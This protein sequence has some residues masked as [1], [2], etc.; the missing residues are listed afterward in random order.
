MTLNPKT[1][2]NDDIPSERNKNVVP[3]YLQGLQELRKSQQLSDVIICCGGVKF[4]AHKVV[5]AANCPYLKAMFTNGMKE[6]TSNEIELK[7]V[8]PTTFGL[9]MDFMYSRDVSI[10]QSNVLD[11]IGASSLLQIEDLRQLSSKFL[12]RQIDC[13][14]VIMIRLFA[15][16]MFL[17]ELKE[18]ATTFLVDNFGKIILCDEFLTIGPDQLID[19]LKFDFL[20]VRSEYVAFYGA[21]RWIQNDLRSRK[22]HAITVLENIRL[23]HF[24]N[25]NYLT[26]IVDKL[27]QEIESPEDCEK[28]LENISKRCS[29][30]RLLGSVTE[31]T[32]SYPSSIRW[33]PQETIYAVGGRNRDSCLSSLESYDPTNNSWSFQEGMQSQRTAVS[34]AALNNHIYCLGGERENPESR[35][36]TLYLN[37]AERYSPQ[38]NRWTDICRLIIPRSFG[39]ATICREKMYAIG[40][41][42]NQRCHNTT[43]MYD[44]ARNEWHLAQPMNCVRSGVCA[45]TIE[46][47]MYV[48]GGHDNYNNYMQHNTVESYDPREGKWTYCMSLNIGRSGATAAA[49]DGKIYLAGGRN[50]QLGNF[51]GLC[52]CYEPRIDRWHPVASMGTVRAWPG[53]AVLDNKFVVLGGYDCTDRLKTVEMYDPTENKWSRCGNMVMCRAG[54]SAC[55]I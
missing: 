44:E 49:L 31:D 27:P 36:E 32:L 10:S 34:M 11:L 24:T 47:R 13:N 38:F 30:R 16:T 6:S 28:F 46:N 19:I 12:M 55:T 23:L 51:F 1:M 8:S 42:N 21:L 2:T 53:S 22:Q 26:R 33:F 20:R 29:K 35:S 3:D 52:E 15:I 54:A 48:I 7:G 50:R 4:P 17:E 25:I 39:A 9:V 18:A 41:E 5:L 40:G 45:T 14:N 37:D 43:E